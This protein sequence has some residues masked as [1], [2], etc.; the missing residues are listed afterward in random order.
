[1]DAVEQ[2]GEILVVDVVA[3]GPARMM[4]SQLVVRL[5]I[6]ECEVVRCNGVQQQSLRRGLAVDDDVEIS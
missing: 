4:L 6:E 2:V 3:A 1:V 5:G